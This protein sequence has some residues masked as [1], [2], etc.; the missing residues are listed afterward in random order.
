MPSEFDPLLPQSNPSPEIS[1]YGYA[2][3]KQDQPEIVQDQDED[4]ENDPTATADPSSSAG[5]PLSTLVGL[6]TF[7]VAV[8]LLITTFMAGS[9]SEPRD[10]PG[11]SRPGLSERVEKILDHT[12]LIGLGILSLLLRFHSLTSFILD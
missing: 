12:P 6:F 1:G 5:S 2:K 11:P 10:P 9:N 3:S 4:E 8:G 7:V